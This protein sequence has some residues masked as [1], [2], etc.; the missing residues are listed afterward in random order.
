METRKYI[1]PLATLQ[2]DNWGKHSVGLLDPGRIEF[3]LPRAVTLIKHTFIGFSFFSSFPIL[4]LSPT[5][6]GN[7][8]TCA[9]KN[10]ATVCALRE[11]EA[12]EIKSVILSNLL[13]FNKPQFPHL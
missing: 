10:L 3:W 8:L 7:H 12:K 13:K 2:V 9:C 1:L 4:L 11:T 5:D 6:P